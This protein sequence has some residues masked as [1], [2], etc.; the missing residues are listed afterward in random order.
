MAHGIINRSNS[1][2]CPICGKPDWCE[3]YPIENGRHF[4]ICHRVLSGLDVVGTDGKNYVFDGFTR[5]GN[6]RYEE[7]EQRIQRMAEKEQ[8]SNWKEQI[9]SALDPCPI[10]G[11]TDKCKSLMNKTSG[12]LFEMCANVK[13]G[14][15]VKRGS[16]WY[17]FAGTSKD[18]CFSRYEEQEARKKRIQDYKNGVTHENKE[19]QHVFHNVAPEKKQ[20]VKVNE[21][22]VR[23]NDYLDKIYR[24]LLECLELDPV[25]R[26]YLLQEGWTDELMERHNIKSF[27]ENDFVRCKYKNYQSNNLYRKNLAKKITDKFGPDALVGVPGAYKNSKGD[28]TFA[29]AKGILFPQ[30]DAKGRLYRLRIRMDFMDVKRELTPQH[31]GDSYY[32]EDG[33]KHFLQPLKGFYTIENGVK[34]FEKNGNGK[35]RNFSSYHANDEKMKEGLEVNDYDSGCEAGNQLGIYYN[36]QRDYMSVAYVT[37]GEKK[38]IFCNDNMHVPFISLPGVNSWSK[39]IEGN[40]GE[41]A[42]DVLA[43]LGVTM[44]VI[45]FDADKEINAAVLKNEANA[46]KAIQNE[47]FAVGIANWDITLGKGIDDLIAGGHKP[48]YEIA[49]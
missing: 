10:C 22:R 5:S 9:R 32:E 30:Y 37:E 43:S 14:R 31:N 6:A 39:L 26:A 13:T 19:E 15:N 11:A 35:Y 47:G 21:V 29:G 46:I 38:G 36:T 8:H 20:I 48:T 2:P 45:A 49:A 17:V 28:W 27:P 33:I 41:R 1:S 42:I 7:L 4:D 18:G 23:D 24:F 12:A 34:V 25:H 16:K 44:F 40:P 3:Y